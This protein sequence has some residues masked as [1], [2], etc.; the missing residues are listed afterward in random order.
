MRCGECGSHELEK[1]EQIRKPFPYKDYP[2]VILNESFTALECRACGNLVLNQKQVKE[3]DLAID[4][5]IKKD[6]VLF[7]NTLLDRE[8]ILIKELGSTIGLTREYLSNLKSGKTIPKFQT[9]NMLKLLFS[10]KKAFKVADPRYD[11]F[12]K[13][14]A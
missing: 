14:K 2:A 11:G 12:R 4:T 5:T 10:D 8:N 7:I 3:L 1:R 13:D 6:L 9:Y